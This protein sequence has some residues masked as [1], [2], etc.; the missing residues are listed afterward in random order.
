MSMNISKARH[1]WGIYSDTYLGW[2]W[3]R[4]YVVINLISRTAA[5]FQRPSC[6]APLV[7]SN[8]WCRILLH[9]LQTE[10]QYGCLLGESLTAACVPFCFYHLFIQIDDIDNTF[11]LFRC[12]EDPPYFTNYKNYEP[13]RRQWFVSRPVSCPCH[14]VLYELNLI[15]PTYLLTAH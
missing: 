2:G 13:V 5:A 7:Q 11:I 1:V 9:L 10:A 12:E 15:A 14:V 3:N 4:L 8:E 6:L